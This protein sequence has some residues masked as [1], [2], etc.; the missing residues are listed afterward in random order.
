MT[1]MNISLPDAMRAFIEQK[2]TQGGYST[3]SEYIRQLVRDEQ[4]RAAKERL[5]ELLMEGIN[6]GPSVEITPEYWA[7]KKAKLL[8]LIEE[9]KP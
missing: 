3:A 4:K 6:S 7:E 2:V 8:K 5:E 9:Q 1:T